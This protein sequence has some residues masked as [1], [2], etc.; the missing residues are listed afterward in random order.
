MSKKISKYEN[1]VFLLLFIVF[2]FLRAFSSS[3]YYFIQATDAVIYLNL[4]KNFPAYKLYNDQLY[5]RHPPM[6]SYFIRFFSS[7][8]EDHIAAMLVSFV[9]GIATFFILYK[10][11][12][13]ISKNSYIAFGT[14]ILFSLSD[15]Y[16]K[17]ST[18][19]IKESFAVM[20]TLASI[21]FYLFFLK[22]EKVKYMV[23]SSLFAI[24]LGLTTDHAIF[25]IP[26][27]A[28][29]YLLFGKKT[30]LKF[31]LIPIIFLML[32]Y[33]SWLGIRLYT[34]THNEYYPASIDGTIVKTNEFGILQL[35]SP[36]F[37][38]EEQKK[39]AM[40]EF[41]M[42][43]FGSAFAPS[44]YIQNIVYMLNLRILALPSGLRLDNISNFLSPSLIF[45]IIIYALLLITAAYGVYKIIKLALKKG[46]KKNGMLLSFFLFIIY[47]FPIT[48]PYIGLR[49]IVTAIIFL[50]IIIS[51]GIFKIGE[52]LKFLNFYKIAIIG[53]ILILVM[54]LPFY[55]SSNSYFILSKKKIVEAA[56]TAKFINQ[57]PKDGVMAQ[58]GYPPELYYQTDKRIMAL[59]IST[60]YMFLIDLYNVSYL[61]YGEF[62]G[63][64]F[65]RNNVRIDD[66]LIK[67][68]NDNPKKFK[69]LRIIE[70]DYS[71][72]KK[73]DHIRIY[74]I[75]K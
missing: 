5:L 22:V 71:A 53:F 65:L 61:V 52:R 24:L 28:V 47:M 13:L 23:Y 54:Y 33:G 19:I 41:A 64:T 10:F 8:F 27:L 72:V 66:D 31:A 74:E 18:G 45:L 40:R 7:F 16:I 12:K 55:Y 4:A 32:S 17:I 51:Y 3:E 11:I 50:Y 62:Y 25:L 75:E 30:S 43:E 9:S 14:L 20:L 59:P 44:Y 2:I 29:C 35:L 21:Y 60:D 57:L 49:Y 6:Y 26:S 37:F 36:H 34:Y 58:V 42:R 69:L 48:Q 70:E 68:I 73:K 15:A 56:S 39:Y 1:I 63:S 46:L 67:Y 38:K